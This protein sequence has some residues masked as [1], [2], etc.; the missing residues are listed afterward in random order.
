[1][2]LLE[3]ILY[4]V[5]VRWLQR[6]PGRADD[7]HRPGRHGAAAL[8]VLPLLWELNVSFTNMSLRNFCDPGF[9]LGSRGLQGFNMFRGPG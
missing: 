7:A 1:M 6:A 2:A 3:G 4:L 5:L 9:P 8:I